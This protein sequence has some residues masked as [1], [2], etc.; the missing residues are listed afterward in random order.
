MKDVIKKRSNKR[1]LR[2]FGGESTRW[3][4]FK[5]GARNAGDAMVSAAQI[6]TF[7]TP[8]NWSG[9]SG[10]RGPGSGVRS[11]AAT[12]VAVAMTP[13]TAGPILIRKGINWAQGTQGGSKKRNNKRR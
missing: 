12:A 7:Q 1:S 3:E 6:A 9:A 11:K 5:K 8:R 2:Q 4:S 10:K 13:F